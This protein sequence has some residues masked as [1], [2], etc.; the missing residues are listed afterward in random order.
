M[1]I[2]LLQ[3]MRRIKEMDNIQMFLLAAENYGV[4]KVDLFQVLVLFSYFISH[5]TL[6]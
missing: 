3:G 4:D 5:I 2:F 6:M 1:D